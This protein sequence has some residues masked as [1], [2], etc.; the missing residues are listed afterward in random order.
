MPKH[1]FFNLKTYNVAS[2]I[3]E[4]MTKRRRYIIDHMDYWIQ[5]KNPSFSENIVKPYH[6]VLND[7]DK[8][9]IDDKIYDLNRN[10]M[11][12]RTYHFDY[13][14]NIFSGTVDDDEAKTK[15][16]SNH[17]EAKYR[18]HKLYWTIRK[19]S[20]TGEAEFD[21]AMFYQSI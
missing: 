13:D 4:Y 8:E 15:K 10:I 9:W 1:E 17:M 14:K 6:P 7:K 2:K 18:N 11:N 12:D 19:N 5:K 3:S 20:V 16:L 21:H